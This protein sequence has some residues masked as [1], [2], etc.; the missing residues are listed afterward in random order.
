MTFDNG[1]CEF[2]PEDSGGKKGDILQEKDGAVAITTPSFFIRLV[3]FQ[4]KPINFL[5]SLGGG[6]PND[7]NLS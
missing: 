4:D 5:K 3:L 1:L 6:E 2:V 7:N